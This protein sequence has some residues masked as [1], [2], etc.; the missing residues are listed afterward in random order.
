MIL[1]AIWLDTHFTYIHT[2]MYMLMLSTV[3]NRATA[4]PYY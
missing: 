1:V 4:I 3:H 2:Y